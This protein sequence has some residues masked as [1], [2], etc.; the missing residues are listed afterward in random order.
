MF[1]NTTCQFDLMGNSFYERLSYFKLYTYITVLH[2]DGQLRE[3][4]I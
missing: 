1:T 3:Y 4:V 2:V